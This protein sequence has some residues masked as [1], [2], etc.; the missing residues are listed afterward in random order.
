MQV[1]KTLISLLA[2]AALLPSTAAAQSSSIN[3]FSPYSMY[4]IG[5]L[6]TPGTLP[7]RSMGGAGVAMRWPTSINLLNPASFSAMERKSFLFDM[8]AEN[9][10]YYNA[11]R[12]DGVTRK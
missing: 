11:Q 1:K 12:R 3:A 7:V 2:V 10:N 8:G 5:E 9:Q 6:N 4:G